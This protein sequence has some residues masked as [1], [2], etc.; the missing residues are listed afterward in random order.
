M[1]EDAR[2]DRDERVR[3]GGGV[4]L[5]FE[6]GAAPGVLDLDL[7]DVEREDRPL[8]AIA[9]EVEQFRARVDVGEPQRGGAPLVGGELGEPAV[10]PGPAAHP[11]G[12]RDRRDV[13]DPE[14]GGHV[15]G[16][17]GERGDDRRGGGDEQQRPPAAVG[18]VRR[19]G[20]VRDPRHR[21]DAA[22][23]AVGEGPGPLG[24]RRPALH[25]GLRSP[26]RCLLDVRG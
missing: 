8:P 18:G 2:L 21:E 10:Q 1:G 13:G 22:R 11:V 3:R 4:L 24:G 25:H 23:D 17:G 14:R 6:G 20:R 15:V 16:F 5:G 19:D 9:A 26:H 12:E 7:R